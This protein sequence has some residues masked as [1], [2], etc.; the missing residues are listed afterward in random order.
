MHNY[1]INENEASVT[2]TLNKLSRILDI[3]FGLL[4]NFEKKR[5]YYDEPKFFYFSALLNDR[6]TKHDGSR[7]HSQASGFS[8]FSEKIALLKCLAESVERYS[9]YV[10]Y[11][12]YTS[13]IG[14]FESI[15]KHGKNALDPMI[16]ARFSETQLKSGLFQKY[17]ITGQ[18]ILNW[19]RCLS[20]KDGS[21]AMAP[22]QFIHLSYK[23]SPDEQALYPSIS[24]GV[25]GGSC[26]SAALVRGIYEVVERDAFMIYYLNQIQAPKIEL[27]TLKN[28]KVNKILSI[29]KRYKLKIISVDLTTDLDIPVVC[30]IILDYSGIGKAVSVGLKCDLDPIE[31]I[32]G[33]I[34]E[35]FHSRGW[36]RSTY[37]KNPRKV[38]PEELQE[39]SSLINRGLLWYPLEAMNNLDFWIHSKNKSVLRRRNIEKT[40][41]A[42]LKRL[43]H[44]FTVLGYDIYWKDLTIPEFRELG[45]HVVKAIIPQLQPLYLNEKYCL[46]GG[47]RL[48][49]VPK[50]LGFKQKIEAELNTY[51]HPFL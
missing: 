43:L 42:R 44:V 51:P 32:V 8:F 33:S 27:N 2:Q 1:L 15:K 38:Q 16:F 35:A 50:R 20:L 37:E 11:H 4:K 39:D 36:L 29:A 48:Y 3:D 7:F 34:S 31:A 18:S 28:D 45:Y 49:D 46:L 40:F 22:C 26:L 17:N 19:T 6:F 47:K 13:Y 10:Y 9:N 41:P 12:R 23:S 30:S 5:H 14:S 21:E 24:T 25:A